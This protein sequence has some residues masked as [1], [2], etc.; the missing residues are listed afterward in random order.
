[1]KRFVRF[2]LGVMVMSLP[3]PAGAFSFT[4]RDQVYFAFGSAELDDAA[5]R[6]LDQI[7]KVMSVTSPAEFGLIIYGHTDRKEVPGDREALALGEK[8]TQAVKDYLMSKGFEPERIRTWSFGWSRPTDPP[9][10][11]S[12]KSRRAVIV[13]NEFSDACRRLKDRLEEGARTPL[14]LGCK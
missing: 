1:M 10:N 12:P 6:V 2:V 5:K 11:D 3:A 13:I 7:F 9:S 14:I 8:R 4:M